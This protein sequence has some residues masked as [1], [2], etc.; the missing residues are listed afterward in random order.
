MSSDS[1]AEPPAPHVL[2]GFPA[3][4]IRFVVVL[5]RNREVIARDHGLSASELRAMFYIAEFRSVTPKDLADHLE[6]TTGAITS[7]AARLVDAGLLHR[8][9]HPKDRR[10][11]YLQLTGH[12]DDVMGT[13]HDDFRAMIAASTVSLTAKQV[14]DF[15]YALASVSERITQTLN[16]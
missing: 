6:M 16:L 3:V 12:G 10:S 7:I 8:I 15:E 11:L 4:A 13:I 1:A 14:Q 9:A 5:E 2:E